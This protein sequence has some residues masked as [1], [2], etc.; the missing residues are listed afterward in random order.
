MKMVQA[1]VREGGKNRA[2]MQASPHIQEK[3]T[4]SLGDKRSKGPWRMAKSVLKGG[5]HFS[6]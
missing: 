2:G 1:R 4:E 6:F 3:E 5:L